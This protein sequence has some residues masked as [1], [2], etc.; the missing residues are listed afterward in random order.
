M[1]ITDDSLGLPSVNQRR[2][3]GRP[4]AAPP[5]SP[6][7]QSRSG[8]SAHSPTLSASYQ[9]LDEVCRGVPKITR[10]AS[11]QGTLSKTESLPSLRNKEVELH[12][13]G[14]LQAPQSIDA[15]DRVLA[16]S[17]SVGSTWSSNISRTANRRGLGPHTWQ[18][19]NFLAQEQTWKGPETVERSAGHDEG[20]ASVVAVASQAEVQTTEN[21]SQTDTVT[22]LEKTA[23]KTSNA[24]V[25]TMSQFEEDNWAKFSQTTSGSLFS[26][27][28]SGSFFRGG[29]GK[30]G[31]PHLAS[32]VRNVNSS[33]STRTPKNLA[34]RQSRRESRPSA[35]VSPID[36]KKRRD[37]TSQTSPS[38]ERVVPETSEMYVQ[39]SELI[40]EAVG[41]NTEDLETVDVGIDPRTDLEDGPEACAALRQEV[42]RYSELLAERDKVIEDLQRRLAECSAELVCRRVLDGKPK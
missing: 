14:Q 42:E 25:Q 21:E 36:Q 39:T 38:P 11:K 32:R 29:D 22:I 23:H 41:T 18:H 30:L 2:Q 24:A 28:S 27:T 12:I 40:V 19:Q 8:G 35:P 16:G 7:Q 37:G 3:H 1:E 20:F 13:M 9:Q 17:R 15:N 33:Q 10:T 26:Q 31:L 6:L 4:R 34:S 5:C